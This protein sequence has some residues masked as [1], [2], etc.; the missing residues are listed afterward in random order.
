MLTNIEKG[1]LVVIK[2]AQTGTTHTVEVLSVKP[3]YERPGNFARFDYINRAESS[4][5]RRTAWP[6]ELLNIVRKTAVKAMDPK[7]QR[8]SEMNKPSASEEIIINGKRYVQK[9]DAKSQDLDKVINP[10]ANTQVHEAVKAPAKPVTSRI[11][12][13]KPVDK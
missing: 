9:V 7:A 13:A 11:T 4:P 5:I 10:E 8:P 12:K 1:D 3:D 6:K 2:D